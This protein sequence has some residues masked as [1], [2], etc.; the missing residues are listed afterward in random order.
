MVNSV[1]NTIISIVVSASFGYCVSLIKSY[2]KRLKTKENNE[3]IQ[4]E[5]L[6]TMIQSNLTNTYIEYSKKKQI[7]DYIFKNWNNLF[8]IYQKLGGNDYCHTLK[9]KMETWEIVH[10]DIL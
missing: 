4:N 1:I 7:P 2:K 6:L 9:K 3:K 10:T 5:A 8:D